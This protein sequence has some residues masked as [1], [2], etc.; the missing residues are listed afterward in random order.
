MHNIK[1]IK[2]HP[3]DNGTNLMTLTAT[4]AYSVLF[5]R[6]TSSRLYIIHTY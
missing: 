6:N 2:E 5:S 1:F 3:L 4:G